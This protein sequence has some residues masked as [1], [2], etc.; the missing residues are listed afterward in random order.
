MFQAGKLLDFLPVRREIQNNASTS[1][2]GAPALDPGADEQAQPPR[3][4][5][6]AGAASGGASRLASG[7][8]LASLAASGDARQSPS[9]HC[10]PAGHTTPSH[11]SS[12]HRPVT[13]SQWVPPAHGVARHGIGAQPS[14]AE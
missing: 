3:V 13:T 9:R 7:A 5:A 2:H 6:G 12:P 11:G 8:V 1:S 10:W 4:V 14:P